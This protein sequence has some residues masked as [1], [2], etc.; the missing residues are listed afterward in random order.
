MKIG[1]GHV[2]FCVDLTW[3]DPYINSRFL[4]CVG[5]PGPIASYNGQVRLCPP[6][7]FPTNMQSVSTG[8]VQ[9]HLHGDW[10][11]INQNNL[12]YP[13]GSHEADSI[14]RQLGYTNS[15]TNSAITQISASSVMSNDSNHVS[16]SKC[17]D[18]SE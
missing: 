17:Y 9:V 16:F 4:I 15:A 14:C 10:R 3:N 5:A 6:N 7:G 13:L 1:R 2:F 8:L 12:S 18:L 11:G